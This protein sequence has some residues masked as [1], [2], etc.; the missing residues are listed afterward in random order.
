VIFVETAASDGLNIVTAMLYVGLFFLAVIAVGEIV[1]S[2][3][4]RRHIRKDRANR[5]Y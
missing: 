1:R 2:A 4:H 5:Q 3:N